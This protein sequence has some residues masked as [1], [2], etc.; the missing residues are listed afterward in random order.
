MD[1]HIPSDGGPS[2]PTLLK[3]FELKGKLRSLFLKYL[4]L[5]LTKV[6]AFLWGFVIPVS[7][8]YFF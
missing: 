1:N 8:V 5:W 7:G 4:I 3:D 6:T 2:F